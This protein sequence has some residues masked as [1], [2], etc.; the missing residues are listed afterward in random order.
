M[1]SEDRVIHFGVELL[2]KPTKHKKEVLQ[3]LYFDLSQLRS[4][5]YDSTD[6]TRPLQPRFYS[7]RGKRSQSVAMFLP[8]RVLMIEEWADI[9][10][11]EFLDRVEAVS[12]RV[13]EIED[14]GP[15]VAH[16]ATIRST[17][18]LTH[19]EDARVFL[20]E[21]VCDQAGKIGQHFQRPIAV[22]GLRFTLPESDEYP[23]NLQIT[24]ESFRQSRNE[25]Y[26]EAK[27]IFAREQISRDSLDVILDHIRGI[28]SFITDRVFPY[29][30]QYDIAPGESE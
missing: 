9:S 19:S 7:K 14:L 2:H 11:S 15:I 28:R 27:G 25:V 18:A 17:F 5:G 8:D 6:F 24:I 26:V 22:G 20:L 23:G 3:K 30:D 4:G 10:M 29:L 16:T 12:T 21:N 13:L 1:Q